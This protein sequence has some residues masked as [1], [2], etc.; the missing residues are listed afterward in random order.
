MENSTYMQKKLYCCK[1][2]QN[3][4][5]KIHLYVESEK[6]AEVVDLP[7]VPVHPTDLVSSMKC[8]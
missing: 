4:S 2:V 7:T 5:G 3:K 8:F 6:I 1:L